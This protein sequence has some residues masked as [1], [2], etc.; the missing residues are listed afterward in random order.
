VE[1]KP[2]EVEIKVE[3]EIGDCRLVETLRSTRV[4]GTLTVRDHLLGF[5]SIG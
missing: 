2:V 5:S 3:V 4:Y 1:V